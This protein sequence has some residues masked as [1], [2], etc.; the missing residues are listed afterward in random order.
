MDLKDT[1]NTC[2]ICK[3][4]GGHSYPEHHNNCPDYLPDFRSELDEILF[5]K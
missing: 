4:Y 2:R 5:R 3:K 1:C